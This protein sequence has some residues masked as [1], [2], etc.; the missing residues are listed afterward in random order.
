MIEGLCY[1][2]QMMGIPVIGATSVICDNES[3]VKNSTALEST[4]KK[5]HNAIAY[6]HAHEA[7]AAGIIR[8]A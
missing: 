2:L 1:K 3:V 5:Q 7:Q 8:V 6:H 4:L